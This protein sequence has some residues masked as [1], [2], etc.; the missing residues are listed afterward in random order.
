[1]HIR[2][3]TAS[4]I[5][6][7]T[8]N[9]HEIILKQQGTQTIIAAPANMAI[10]RSS[11]Y[12]GSYNNST[13]TWT[14]GTAGWIIAGDGHA[15]FS[16]ASI[17]GTVKAG[18][19][20]IDQYNRWKTDE[21]GNEII[22]PVFRVGDADNYAIYDGVSA[23]IIKGTVEATAGKIGGWN[24]VQ[25]DLS[26]GDFAGSILLGPTAGPTAIGGATS[27]TGALSINAP[28]AVGKEKRVQHTGYYSTYEYWNTNPDSKIQNN[29]EIHPDGIMYQYS[30]NDKFE[31]QYVDETG[32]VYIVINGTP[33]QICI[34]DCATVDPGGGGGGSIPCTSQTAS[35]STEFCY[36][37]GGG[38]TFPYYKTTITYTCSPT[39]CNTCSATTTSACTSTGVECGGP[40]ADNCV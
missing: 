2:A 21:S 10:L 3:L 36:C 4:K 40:C 29:L 17:R 14:N 32:K 30:E 33:F 13:S 5:T 24:I 18:S 15:E 12:N 38:L 37:G 22:N 8:I 39:G 27:K 7:G 20:F 25:N 28:T 19:I 6:A 34:G 35:S 9:A 16:S 11:N 23:F 31:F 26:A 1:M